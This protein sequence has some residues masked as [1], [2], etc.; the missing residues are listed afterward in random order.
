MNNQLIS[1]STQRVEEA[2]RSKN[3]SFQ[4]MQLPTTT[5]TAQ[6]AATALG[7]TIDQIV[8]SLI[9]KTKHTH[10]P[11]LIVASGK[12]KVHEAVI[13]Q[14]LGEE[15]IR[16]DAE[17]VK[18]VTGFPIGGVAPIGHRQPLQTLIDKD[19][20]TF[21][22]LWAAAGTPNTVFSFKAADLQAMTNGKVVAIH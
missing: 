6:Q 15:I 5:H 12:N 18:E 3:I 21:D 16:A 7:C 11:I 20:L 22:I 8:K 19:L 9:F 13:S 2:L 14:A 1:K 17:F 10:K 4:L